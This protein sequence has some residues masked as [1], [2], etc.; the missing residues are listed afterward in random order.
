MIMLDNSTDM[1]N[2]AYGSTYS[3]SANHDNYFGYFDSLGCYCP[4]IS[5]RFQRTGEVDYATYPSTGCPASAAG[6]CTVGQYNGNILNW[7]TMSGFAIAKRVVTGGR[8]T[9]IPVPQ[10]TLEGD[11]WA[12]KSAQGCLGVDFLHKHTAHNN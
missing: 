1:S 2:P 6:V 10:F 5:S 12:A 4:D 9:S 7:A 11:D 8:Y 3:P